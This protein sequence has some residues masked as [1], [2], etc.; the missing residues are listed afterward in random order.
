M[1]LRLYCMYV[2]LL[3]SADSNITCNYGFGDQSYLRMIYLF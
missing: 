1:S 2:C 3:E